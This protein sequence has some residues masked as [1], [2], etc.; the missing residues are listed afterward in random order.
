MHLENDEIV[1][2]LQCGGCKHFQE[3]N[4]EKTMFYCDIKHKILFLKDDIFKVSI[5][6]KCEDKEKI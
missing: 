6:T 3:M 1:R 4:Y 5:G 2:L